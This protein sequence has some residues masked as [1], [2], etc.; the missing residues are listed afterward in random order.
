MVRNE[1][2]C[3]GVCAILDWHEDRGIFDGLKRFNLSAWLSGQS[4]K[5]RVISFQSSAD[6]FNLRRLEAHLHQLVS[7]RWPF[8]RNSQS[9]EHY[10]PIGRSEVPVDRSEERRVGKEC[11]STCRSRWSPNI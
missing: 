2:G 6:L 7:P 10:L 5:Q 4:S 1:G 11:V 8:C 9:G 3:L